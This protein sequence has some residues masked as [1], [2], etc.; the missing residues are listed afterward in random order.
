[1]LRT[2]LSLILSIPMI[3]TPLSQT[4]EVNEDVQLLD[5]FLQQHS[6]PSE[7]R[8]IA[9]EKLKNGE[10]L[11]SESPNAK[12]L[13]IKESHSNNE[14]VTVFYYP[15]GSVKISSVPT[16]STENHGFSLFYVS[17]CKFSGGNS[18]VATWTNC[19]A[20]ETHYYGTLGVY[21]NY[22]YARNGSQRISNYWT[23]MSDSKYGHSG[24]SVSRMSATQIRVRAEV[25]TG[26]RGGMVTRWMDVFVNK[27]VASTRSGG[28]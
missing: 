21:F 15:D 22:E 2:T 7:L 12:P 5:S 13:S 27:G 20:S 16:L 6:V 11:D 10:T 23:P 4:T 17:K 26:L 19:Y 28:M 24:L 14:N 9:I 25:K 1:M 3:L 8:E 18:F